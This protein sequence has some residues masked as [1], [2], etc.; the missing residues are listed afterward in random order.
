MP[1]LYGDA[2]Q[3]SQVLSGV[4]LLRKEDV[5]LI[6]LPRAMLSSL[7]RESGGDQA[8]QIRSEK[9]KPCW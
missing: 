5:K 8:P 4:V 9:G 7:G 3:Q 1:H 6:G 2:F